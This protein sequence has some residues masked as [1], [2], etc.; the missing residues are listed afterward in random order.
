MNGRAALL[1]GHQYP[2]VQQRRPAL[3]V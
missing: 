1:R 2:A 3:A